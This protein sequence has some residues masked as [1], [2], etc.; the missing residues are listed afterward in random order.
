MTL[1]QRIIEYRSNEEVSQ[2][3]FA[4][5]AG[6]DRTTIIK[7]ENGGEVSRLTREKIERVL[8]GENDD[9]QG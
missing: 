8:K 1:S 3:E 5:R 6:V 2:A 9:H 4:N 7:A